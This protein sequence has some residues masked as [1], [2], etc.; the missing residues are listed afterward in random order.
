MLPLKADKAVE[1]TATGGKGR[2]PMHDIEHKS[3]QDD[4]AVEIT[5][6]QPQAEPTF[7][8]AQKG[9]TTGRQKLPR[10]WRYVIA[11]GTVLIVLAVIFAGI[12]SS[13]KQVAN[14]P[15]HPRSTPVTSSSSLPTPVATPIQ[16]KVWTGHNVSLTIAGGVAYMG[17][18][19][20]AVYA[21]ST[22]DRT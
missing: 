16:S 8:P 12:L 17:A 21:L 5:P 14:Q 15:S 22:R 3:E 7:P 9:S 11:G 20:N 19:D 10:A 2:I 18:A 6:L 4:S 13:R 1:K